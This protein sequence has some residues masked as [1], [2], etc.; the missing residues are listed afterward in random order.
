MKSLED[1]RALKELE[2]LGVI[3][4]ITGRAIY[5]GDLDLSE[6]VRVATGRA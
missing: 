5:T 3:G 6:A 1:I 2:P 4:A